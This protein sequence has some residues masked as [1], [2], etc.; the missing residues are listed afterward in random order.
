M[1]KERRL[2]FEI[3][4]VSNLLKREIGSSR[5]G[6]YVADVTG[7]NGFI[8][9]YLAEHAGC[10]IFQRDLEKKFSVRR[11]TMSNII[12]RMEQKGFLI[13]TPVAHDARLKKLTLTEKGWEIHSIMEGAVDEAEAKLVSG[14]TGEEIEQMYTLLARMRRNLEF[15]SKSQSNL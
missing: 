2:G 7:T 4:T 3:K 11:S 13:R 12:L 1:E 9:S 6:K 5:S 8:I 10:D 15:D 14:F